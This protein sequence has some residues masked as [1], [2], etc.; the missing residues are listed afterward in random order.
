LHDWRVVLRVPESQVA[1]VTPQQTGLVQVSALPDLKLP[2]TVQRIVPVAEAHDGKMLFRVDAALDATTARLR[3]GMEG[4]GQI[5]AGRF[6]L[7]WIW[8]RSLLHWV[9]LETWA[10]LP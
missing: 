7:V 6:R 1:D 9:R 5:D 3:P 10:W 4:L 2:F 8:F